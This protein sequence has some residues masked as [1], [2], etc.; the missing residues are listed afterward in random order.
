[1]II[2]NISPHPKSLVNLNKFLMPGDECDIG[3]FTQKQRD[4]CVELQEG[5]RKGEL[6]C[7]GFGHRANYNPRVRLQAAKERIQ[8]GGATQ[9]LVPVM[10]GDRTIFNVSEE[11]NQTRA[12]SPD[13]AQYIERKPATYRNSEIK[14]P[15]PPQMTEGPIGII[16]KDERGI[17]T[18]KP[19]PTKQQLEPKLELNPTSSV[20]SPTITSD[21]IREIMAQRCISFCTNG[22]KCKRWTVTGYEYCIQHMPKKL[23]EDYKNK[24]KQQFFKD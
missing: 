7:I 12:V 1:M 17:F 5:F 3:E 19:L 23:L 24:K 2:K 21:R 14:R 16:E 11:M 6:V 20:K 8:K 13:K 4:D 22:S 10:G 15:D 9:P 18:V